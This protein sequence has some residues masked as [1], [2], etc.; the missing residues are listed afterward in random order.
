M[1]QGQAIESAEVSGWSCPVLD[2]G[3][4]A[5]RVRLICFKESFGIFRVSPLESCLEPLCFLGHE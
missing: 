3:E 1:I 5:E 2:L 4:L